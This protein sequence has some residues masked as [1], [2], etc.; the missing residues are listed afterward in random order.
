[1]EKSNIKID[2]T[3]SSPRV[4]FNFEENKLIIS[5]IC[6]PA[7]PKLFFEPIIEAFDNYQRMYNILTIDIYLDY[8]NTGS[9]KCLL[10]L[11]QKA[12][13]NPNL[14]INTIVNWIISND[15]TELKEAGEVFEEITGLRFNYLNQ[16]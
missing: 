15:D 14:K 6:T 10:T 4:V 5:G 11:F 7:N 16:N 2:S 3:E 12:S 1:M 13:S 8:F 9:S